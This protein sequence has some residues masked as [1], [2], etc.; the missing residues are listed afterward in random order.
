LGARVAGRE[1]EGG[2]GPQKWRMGELCTGG[3]NSKL[4]MKKAKLSQ[5]KAAEDRRTPRCWRRLPG[6]PKAATADGGRC[7]TAV[8]RTRRSIGVACKGSAKEGDHEVKNMG[9]HDGSFSWGAGC[10]WTFNGRRKYLIFRW[11]RRFF[12]IFH[13]FFTPYFSHSLLIISELHK[14]HGHKRRKQFKCKVQN[15]DF[16]HGPA[17]TGASTAGG[18]G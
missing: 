15:A 7:H 3:A 9:K 10:V 18:H 13:R 1:T 8:S 6:R 11:L 14:P 16:N 5:E 17:A 12:T 2:A 4:K